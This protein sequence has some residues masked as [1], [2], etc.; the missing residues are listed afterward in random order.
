M[1]FRLLGPLEVWDRG[2]PV[3]LGGSKQRALLAILLLHAN[4]VV[5]R[6]RL[7][8]ELWGSAPPE[9]AATALQVHVSQLRKVLGRDAIV[10]RSPGYMVSVGPGALDLDR[11]EELA[12]AARDQD[13]AAAAAALREALALWR[14]PA[15]AR[16]GC[17]RRATGAANLPE[18]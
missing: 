13:A 10:T 1:D 7:I 18:R 2:R 8:D 3:A 11:F 14:G 15:L 9:T 16:R 4:E 17:G 6:D 5:S 12:A